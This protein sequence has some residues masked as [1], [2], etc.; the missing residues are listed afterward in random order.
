MTITNTVTF[1]KDEKAEMSPLERLWTR[2]WQ[3]N[4][5]RQT[6]S[7]IKGIIKRQAILGSKAT[8]TFMRPKDRAI[9]PSEK[10]SKRSQMLDNRAVQVSEKARL[11]LNKP[12][13]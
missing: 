11:S 13:N 3:S 9:S 12:I 7:S 1:T 8:T 10:S 5:K 4:L 6:K 2:K